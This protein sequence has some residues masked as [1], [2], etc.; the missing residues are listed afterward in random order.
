MI[1]R[2]LINEQI[3]DLEKEYVN[4]IIDHFTTWKDWADA[5]QKMAD[6]RQVPEEEIPEAFVLEY[7]LIRLVLE[8]EAAGKFDWANPRLREIF[9]QLAQ[10]PF[11]NLWGKTI[12]QITLRLAESIGAKTLVEVGAG[13]GNLTQIMIQQIA[14]KNMAMKLIVSDSDPIVLEHMETLKNA[15]PGMDIT[16]MLWDIKQPPPDELRSKIEPPCLLYERASILYATI[17]AIENIAAVSD[18]VVFGDMFNYTGQ[19]YAYDEISKRIGAHPLFYS[20]IKPVVEKYFRDHFMFDQR[21]Q[22]ELQFPSTTMMIAF[23]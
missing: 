2:D 14:E 10:S 12:T 9:Q 23:K 15:H 22:E 13:R 20:E 19:L 11:Y 17:P 6:G 21:A 3:H 18:I 5:S 1:T 8:M 16:T 4:F 7:R